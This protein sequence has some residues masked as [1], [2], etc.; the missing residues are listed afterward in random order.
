MTS[1]PVSHPSNLLSKSKN[2]SFFKKNLF[3]K[4]NQQKES[5]EK[6]EVG[7]LTRVVA[8]TGP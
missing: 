6:A 2:N 8:S 1:K 4:T 7:I 3:Y 5:K